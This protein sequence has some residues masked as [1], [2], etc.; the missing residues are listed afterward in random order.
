MAHRLQNPQSLG[1]SSPMIMPNGKL[2]SRKKSYPL[3]RAAVA[4]KAF[5]SFDIKQEAGHGPLN[6]LDGITPLEKSEPSEDTDDQSQNCGDL[7]KAD[8]SVKVLEKH[9]PSRSI[10]ERNN[11]AQAK[12]VATTSLSAN[13]LQYGLP[14]GSYTQFQTSMSCVL[15]ACKVDEVHRLAEGQVDF[16]GNGIIDQRDLLALRGCQPTSEDNYLSNFVI[17]GYFSLIAKEA[18]YQGKGVELL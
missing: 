6:D 1:W 14:P 15:S 17:E 11:Y 16:K 2:P 18:F 10:A 12:R 3:L 7:P 8:Q 13:H 9:L 4:L 5:S